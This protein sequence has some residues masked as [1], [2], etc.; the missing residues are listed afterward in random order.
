MRVFCFMWLT[1]NICHQM[2]LESG[3]G[4]SSGKWPLTSNGYD[5]HSRRCCPHLISFCDVSK[6]CYCCSRLLYTTLYYLT[7]RYSALLGA[8]RRY[9]TL[10]GATWRYSALLDATLRYSTLLYAT[11]RYSTLLYATLRYSTLLYATLRYSTLLYAT[12]H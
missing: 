4:H 3:N 8:T 1:E 7:T 6:I 5:L 12:L 11:L 2:A 10:L 9:L